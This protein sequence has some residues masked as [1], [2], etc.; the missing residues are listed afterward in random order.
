MLTGD[1]IFR[2]SETLGAFLR[3][4]K[5][6]D[7]ERVPAL[8]ILSTRLPLL[9]ELTRQIE[10]AVLAS[11]EVVDAAS[12]AL[13]SLRTK[14]ITQ[15]KRILERVQSLVNT[16]K[17]YL[18]EPIYTERA[19]RYVLPVKAA[20]KG[21]VPGI[22]HDSSG[23]GQ[24]LYIEPDLVLQETNKLREIEGAEREEV[25][26][27]LHAL[28]GRIGEQAN[29]IVDGLQAVGEID[30]YVAFGIEAEKSGGVEPRLV[31]DPLLFIEA[32]HHPLLEREISVPIDISLGGSAGSLLITGPNTGGKTVCL[33]ILGLFTFIIGCGAFPP[34]RAVTFGPFTAVFAD[35]GDEQSLQQ[36]LST[37]SGHVKNLSRALITASAGAL[38]L[39]D[40]I[41]AG[42]D[43]AEG[44]AIGK[45]VLSTLC[46]KET[47]IAATTH[48]GELK[49]F[50]LNHDRFRTAAMEFDLDTLK[51]T[52]KLIEGATGASHAF[53]I[54]KRYGL[55]TDVASRAQEFLSDYARAERG[56]SARLDALIA[57][58]ITKT[59]QA[60]ETKNAAAEELSRLQSEREHSKAKLA[61]IRE[62]ALGELAEAI[63]EMRSKYRELLE[64]TVHLQGAKREEILSE[65][66]RVEETFVKTADALR[67][68]SVKSPQIKE[69]DT[70][71]VRGRAETAIVLELQKTRAVVQIGS[72]RF[73]VHPSEL[74]PARRYDQPVKRARIKLDQVAAATISSE[75]M[76]RRMRAEEA[77]V[78]LQDYFDDAALANLHRTRIVHGKGDGVLR[79]VVRDFLAKRKDVARY[80]DADASEG[81]AGVTIVEFK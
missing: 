48:Y 26:R 81:G 7:V 19:G 1:T 47:V 33:K 34:A 65:A 40:E 37:F 62:A 10:S 80:N 51:P 42:T 14:K 56:K 29:D 69:G 28:S 57:E 60:E 32:G 11:G 43:P 18:Q 36:S 41:G 75:L 17:S 45:A 49:E 9:N 72:L 76:V 79:K 12:A 30:L 6:I 31:E 53:E 67:S 58:A 16:L 15:Q 46:E 21:K 78:A 54:A 50:A 2:V 4:R 27:I 22:L 44:A 74:E 73:S 77:V 3:L 24:T 13:A 38:C 63:R 55:P 20:Y 68:P 5:W 70:V 8:R 35:I 66:R 59:A 39:F 25:E 64:Q 52:Y 71:R 61:N 23:S